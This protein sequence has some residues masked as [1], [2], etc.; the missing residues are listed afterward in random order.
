MCEAISNGCLPWF[1]H[2]NNPASTQRISR[3]RRRNLAGA[4]QASTPS[5]FFD[6]GDCCDHVRLEFEVVDRGTVSPDWTGSERMLRPD[7]LYRWG[8]LVDHNTN[9]A[10]AG[11]GSCIFMHI[12]R[13]PGKPTV[14][15]TAMPQAEIESLLGWL[16]PS[17]GPLLVQLPESRYRSLRKR[18]HLPA[19][20][21][22]GG[23]RAR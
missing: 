18:W 14:G 6:G 8:I 4:S 10:V 11:G 17:R 22:A 12:W 5:G 9:P 19:V 2:D 3:L 23:S 20:P 15:C 13:G 7:E 16:D 1:D 21:D